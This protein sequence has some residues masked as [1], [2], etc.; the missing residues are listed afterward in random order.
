M[1]GSVYIREME[2]LPAPAQLMVDDEYEADY[3]P[4][5]MACSI[6]PTLLF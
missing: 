1:D 4:G 5:I 2:P 3:G 6:I